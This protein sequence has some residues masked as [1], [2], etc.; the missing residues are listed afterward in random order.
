[1]VWA[2]CD[3]TATD[4]NATLLHPMSI[5]FMYLLPGILFLPFSIRMLGFLIADEFLL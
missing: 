5:L 3:T 1:M 2:G 4:R